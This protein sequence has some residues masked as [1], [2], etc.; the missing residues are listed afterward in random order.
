MSD[1]LFVVPQGWTQISQ[2]MVDQIGV[3]EITNFMATS[4]YH[5]LGEAIRALGG[6]ES[7]SDAVFFNSEIL[8]VR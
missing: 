8:A 3:S 7:I 1:F 6:V 2:E 4:N 5:G